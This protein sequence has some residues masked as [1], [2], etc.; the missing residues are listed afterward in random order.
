MSFVKALATLA[1]GFAAAKGYEKFK[2]MGGMAGVE[3]SLRNAGGAGGMADQMGDM[4]EKMGVPG[5]K[6]AVKD[7]VAKYAPQA[8]D[9]ADAA[10]AGLGGLMASMQSAY[11]QGAEKMGEMMSAVTGATPASPIIEENAKLMIR[12]MIQAAKA[13]GQID[14]DEKAKIMSHL[15]NATDEE[16]AFVEAE[17]N[18]PMDLNGLVAATGAT[19]KAQVYSTSLMTIRPDQPVEQ[20]Y[21]RQLAAGL[22]LD[23]ATVDGLHAAMGVAPLPAQA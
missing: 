12:A 11:A 15:A 18:G 21:L 2:Q 9:A 6:Q 20:A 17:M 14:A 13:D 3:Q 16:R 23:Q 22:G 7:M 8:A 4:A 10:Q 19:M 5:G 1:A